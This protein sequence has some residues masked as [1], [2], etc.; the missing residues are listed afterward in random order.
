MRILIELPSWLGDAVMATP[1]IEN[2]MNYYKNSEFIFIGSLVSIEALMNHPKVSNTFVIEKKY[3]SLFKISKKLGPFDIFYSFRGSFRSK[4]LK[5]F[6]SSK[7]KFQFDKNNYQQNLHQVQKYNNFINDCMET[8]LNPGKLILHPSLNHKNHNLK[9]IFGINPGS[10]YGVSKRWSPIKFSQIA[11]ELSN[12]FDIL[13]FGGPKEKQIAAEIEKNLISRGVKNYKN[14]STKTSVKDLINHIS[15][16]DLFVTG[17][18][19]PMHIAAAFE[20]P[21]VAIFGPTK[22]TETSQWMN[23]KNINIKKNLSC[24]PCMKR[25]CPLKHNNCMKLIKADEVLSALKSLN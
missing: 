21:T 19:G 4:I 3:S 16:L 24:Q 9:P 2:I 1:A 23:D 5:L 22:A 14:I 11:S 18:T 6:I 13:I 7:K 25:K 15:T 8:R 10:S 17:D 20:V 12:N